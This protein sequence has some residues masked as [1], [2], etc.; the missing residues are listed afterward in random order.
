MKNAIKIVETGLSFPGAVFREL[1]AVIRSLK[2]SL[3]FSRG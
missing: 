2:A 3:F 1:G